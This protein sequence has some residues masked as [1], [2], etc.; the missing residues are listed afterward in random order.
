MASGRTSYSNWL[1]Y[2]DVWQLIYEH[3]FLLE[4]EWIGI[5]EINNPAVRLIQRGPWRNPDKEKQ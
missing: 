1:K 2:K 4:N 3:S 5:Q